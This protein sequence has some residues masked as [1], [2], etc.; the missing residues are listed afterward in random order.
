VEVKENMDNRKKQSY[1]SKLM[2]C[3]K[4]DNA[5][6][7]FDEEYIDL[8]LKVKGDTSFMLD[9]H[10]Y[11]GLRKELL[12]KEQ[13][14]KKFTEEYIDKALMDFLFRV[15]EENSNRNALAYFSELVSKIE[16]YSQ[17]QIVYIPLSGVKLDIESFEIG[18]VKLF[19][20]TD[21]LYDSL[22]NQLETT[23]ANSERTAEQKQK[24]IQLW[25]GDLK[26]CVCA[27]YR[28]VAEPDKARNRAIEECQR[29]FDFLRFSIHMMGQDHLRLAVG[30]LGEVNPH[31]LTIPVISSDSEHFLISSH[32]VGPLTHFVIDSKTVDTM[33][34]L[35]I[36]HVAELLS[37]ELAED[38]FGVAVLRGLR[39]FSNAQIQLV[40]E[41]QLLNLMTC[42]E[43]FLTR[44]G[45]EQITNTVAEGVAFVL[46]SNVAES[47]WLKSRIHDFY[48][49]RSRVSHG[50]HSAIPDSL[51]KEF[52][53]I[54]GKFLMYMIQKLGVFE[55]R[56]DLDEWIE[57]QKFGG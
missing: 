20:M 10:K 39:W 32:R 47:R 56:K 30:F 51:L 57:K 41:N 53:D 25:L 42:L 22:V 12:E 4:D 15:R 33:Q 55:L 7:P 26:D 5:T 44:R 3:V 6:S 18:N 50:G 29:A 11:M 16:D 34:E 17:E 43:T 2:N 13:W 45:I 24:S 38:S 19:S 28:C 37:Q 31:I 36:F 1:A 46:G 40:S 14:D 27:E 49:Y 54:V 8:D 23:M 21:E 52:K 35:G 9:T 48:E